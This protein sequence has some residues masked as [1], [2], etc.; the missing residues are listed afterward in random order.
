MLNLRFVYTDGGFHVKFGFP[1]STSSDA[2]MLSF[3]ICTVNLSDSWSFSHGQCLKSGH[4]ILKPELQQKT[5]GEDSSA[6][7]YLSGWPRVSFPIIYPASD[8]MQHKFFSKDLH[9]NATS[10]DWDTTRWIYLNLLLPNDSQITKNTQHT[11]F[12][13]PCMVS[14]SNPT[15]WGGAAVSP[16]PPKPLFGTWVVC[17]ESSPA[18]GKTELGIVVWLLQ[19]ENQVAWLISFLRWVDVQTNVIICTCI[20]KNTCNPIRMYT[21]NLCICKNIS[22]LKLLRGGLRLL[23]LLF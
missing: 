18:A 15:T 3:Q 5:I 4:I 7:H 2:N 22:T 12:Y 17:K 8:V 9:L 11:T 13:I 16:S 21:Y 1:R 6:L 23:F 14:S 20:C 10:W 19:T